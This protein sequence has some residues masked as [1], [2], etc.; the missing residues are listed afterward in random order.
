MLFEV[1]G[2]V[3]RSIELPGTDSLICIYTAEKGMITAVAKGAKWVSNKNMTAAQLFC[4]GHFLI[5]RRGDKYWVKEAELLEGFFD[6][7]SDIEQTALASYVCDVVNDTSTNQPEEDVLRLALNTLYAICAKASFDRDLVKAAFEMRMACLLGFMPDLSGC[8]HC[9]RTDG[10]FML[11]VMD[12]A[13]VCDGCRHS[14]ASL[15]PEEGESHIVE[16][17]SPGVLSALRYV[18]SCPLQKLFS[19][20]LHDI[21]KTLFCRLTESYLTNQLERTFKSLSFYHKVK[22]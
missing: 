19:F 5:Y 9:G 3:T 8:V 21:D 22:E 12:G 16:I 13:L 7:R 18:V 20:R 10:D 2:L 4:Y 15:P 11:Y 17:V 6:L 14:L 1:N